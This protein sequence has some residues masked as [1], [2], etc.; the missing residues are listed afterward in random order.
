MY[1]FD[2]PTNSLIFKFN[3]VKEGV[4]FINLN[5][6]ILYDFKKKDD[7]FSSSVIRVPLEVL[8]DMPLERREWLLDH[9]YY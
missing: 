2:R 7:I 6:R 8:M 4:V 5:N 1:V 9:I 3:V